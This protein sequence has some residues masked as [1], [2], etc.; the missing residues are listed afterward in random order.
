MAMQTPEMRE[1]GAALDPAADTDLTAKIEPFD[2]FWE[3]P[4]DIERGYRTVYEFYKHNYLR[5]VPEDREAPVLV[6]SCGP[7][8]FVDMLARH[9]RARR[10]SHGLAS[11]S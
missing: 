10:Q 5:F 2:S 3:G 4:E 1:A 9:V 8:Y 7:G 11:A 6:I